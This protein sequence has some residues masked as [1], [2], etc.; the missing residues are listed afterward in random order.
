MLTTVPHQITVRDRQ[1]GRTINQGGMN[2]AFCVIGNVGM[3][4]NAF[5][6]ASGPAGELTAIPRPL[7]EF[8][9]RNR[10]AG[11]ERAKGE[12]KGTEGEGKG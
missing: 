4:Q 9:E 1:G 3:R 7:A 2:D 12:G 8:L 10:K 11:M 5:A 6:A